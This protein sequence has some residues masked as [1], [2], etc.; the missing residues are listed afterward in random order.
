MTR[1]LI[2][3]GAG[4]IGHHLVRALVDEG[5]EVRVLDNLHRGSFERDGLAG[6]T[7]IAGDV[8][9]PVACESA[10]AGCDCGHLAA[11]SNVMAAKR[12]RLRSRPTSAACGMWL[13]RWR[14]GRFLGL[15]SRRRARCTGISA[16]TGRRRGP[17]RPKNLYR[18]SKVAERRCWPG[19]AAG[20]GAAV[21]IL[22]LADVI[23]PGDSERVVPNWLAA[24]RA[25]QPLEVYG[26]AQELDF[27]PVET[28]IQAIR[29]AMG[30]PPLKGPVNVGRPAGGALEA[31]RRVLALYG[32]AAGSRVA[33]RPEVVRFAATSPHEV[34][35]GCGA[36]GNPLGACRG[37]R[38]PHGEDSP[39]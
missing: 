6:A 9:D 31:R 15:C 20:G 23:G 36:P 4:F 12:L 26:G 1:V 14:A 27:V 13:E 19:G 8:R 2:T 39:G 5:C 11:Q 32:G 29:A 3:G 10:A 24:A 7:L 21:V 25:R 30:C 34:I 37:R 33:R 16:N 17:C 28:C 22:R 35:T 38:M 18:A